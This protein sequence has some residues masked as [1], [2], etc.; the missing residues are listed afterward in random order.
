MKCSRCSNPNVEDIRGEG[1]AVVAR[2]CRMCG[3]RSDR[4]GREIEPVVQPKQEQ[5]IGGTK[6]PPCQ[7]ETWHLQKQTNL[8]GEVMAYVCGQCF[9]KYRPVHCVGCGKEFH[10]ELD[11]RRAFP[12]CSSACSTN[13]AK[14][15]AKAKRAEEEAK[16]APS[17]AVE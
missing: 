2:F 17:K 3:K 6:P 16:R 9:K 5:L 10:A 14:A 12:A 7:C 4:D 15:R 11:D 13:A 1:G 8:A